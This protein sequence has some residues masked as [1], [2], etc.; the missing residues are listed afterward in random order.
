MVLSEDLCILASCF[1]FESDDEEFSHRRVKELK[2]CS[3][4]GRNLM[5]SIWKVG[6]A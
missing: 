2:I 5:K 1:F 6:N 3:Y 4:T